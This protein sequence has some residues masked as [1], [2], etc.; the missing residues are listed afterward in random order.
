MSA[1]QSSS[2]PPLP[3]G[4]AAPLADVCLLMEGSYPYVAGGVSTWTHDLIKSHADLTFHVV[5]LV[6][7]RNARKL[8]YELPGNVT[9]LTHVYL[10]IRPPAGV[11]CRGSRAFWRRWSIPCAACSRAAGW[12]RWPTSSA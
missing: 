7:D 5:A 6:A 1:T 10:Q 3:E 9:G 4:E 11:G 8:A 12:P 2:K